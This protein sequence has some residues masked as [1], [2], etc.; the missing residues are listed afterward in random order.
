MELTIASSNFD[1]SYA[2]KY[3]VK[4]YL[5][6]IDLAQIKEHHRWQ[7]KPFSEIDTLGG[8]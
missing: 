8:C 6:F 4:I 5:L 1:F 2:V 7:K 3:I